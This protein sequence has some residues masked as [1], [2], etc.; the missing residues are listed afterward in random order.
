M[1]A[2]D[3]FRNY[4]ESINPPYSRKD[5]LTIG[6]TFFLLLVIP[7]TTIIVLQAREPRSRADVLPSKQLI[8]NDWT[9]DSKQDSFGK[10]FTVATD[11]ANRYMSVYYNNGSPTSSSWV[12][13]AIPGNPINDFQTEQYPRSAIAVSGN[14]GQIVYKDKISG[15]MIAIRFDITRDGQNNVTSISFQPG[16]VLDTFTYARWPS[17]IIAHNGDI[18]ALWSHTAPGSNF[19]P[20][21]ITARWSVSSGWTSL[22]KASGSFD[23]VFTHTVDSTTLI[24]DQIAHQLVENMQTKAIYVIF[25]RDSKD[26]LDI[27]KADFDGANWNW[28]SAKLNFIPDTHGDFNQFNSGTAAYDPVTGSVVTVHESKTDDE[29][30]GLYYPNLN[31]NT[32]VIYRRLIVTRISGD[33]SFFNIA[34]SAKVNPQDWFRISVSPDGT[35]N[36]LYSQ[37][38]IT[39][40]PSNTTMR[41]ATYNN[42]TLTEKAIDTNLGWGVLLEGTRSVIADLDTTGTE[43]L[44]KSYFIDGDTVS[45][46]DSGTPQVSITSPADGATI[47]SGIILV[48]VSDSDDTGV[49][50]RELYIDGKYYLGCGI[51]DASLLTNGPHTLQVKSYDGF[52]KVG[53]SP[54]VTININRTLGTDNQSP[55]ISFNPP[56]TASGTVI[57]NPVFSDNVGATIKNVCINDL[58]F[59]APLAWD[60]TKYEN[61][62]YLVQARAYDAAGN[63]AMS[64]VVKVTVNN[65][66]SC[67][68]VGDLNCDNK[69]D[70]FD[71]S[72]LLTRWG[73]TDATA[74]LNKNG[75]VDIFDLSILLSHWET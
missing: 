24:N 11:W 53:V 27:V 37:R 65:S 40:S 9:M 12:K 59:S 13:V 15:N 64:N 16:V 29:P 45:I 57:L 35:Y 17:E 46:I 6:I 66:G 73:T 8:G 14:V 72:I 36:L 4:R 50:F 71:L 56:L 7:L 74:D 42:N 60:T 22:N 3:L 44:Y 67:T 23:V 19:S 26:Y 34:S 69:V 31:I 10:Y 32:G 28:E 47:T 55:T 43:Y 51:L 58:G 48:G 41:L 39:Q 1:R 25:Q 33:D 20:A 18:I 70:I 54:I 52:G 5:F 75:S 68:K 38:P 21:L 49:I 30:T 62:D 63:G 2:S 61:T